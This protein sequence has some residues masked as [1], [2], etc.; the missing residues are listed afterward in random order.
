[1]V[2]TSNGGS[3]I[4][5]HRFSL[6]SDNGYAFS[7]WYG[8]YQTINRVN[9]LLRIADR[10]GVPTNPADQATYNSIL[11]QAKALRAYSYMQLLAFFSPD[12]TDG[13]RDGIMFLGD[14]VPGADTDYPKVPNSQ[15]FAAMEA[16]LNF[17]YD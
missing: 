2:G 11:G 14:D 1:G 12:M 13:S 17:A 7:I 3:D 6:N 9:R 5:T 15:V 4:D 16:D 10:I 8:R